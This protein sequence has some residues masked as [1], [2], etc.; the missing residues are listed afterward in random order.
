MIPDIAAKNGFSLDRLLTLC[1]VVDAGS[2][3]LAAGP[4]PTRQ[5]QFSRQIKELEEAFGRKLFIREGKRLKATELGEQLARMA[6]S[7]FGAVDALARQEAGRPETLAIGA[8]EA[9]LRWLLV[10]NFPMLRQLD[11]PIHSH[12]RGLATDEVVREIALGR[13][14]AGVIRIDAVPEGLAFE[15]VGKLRYVLVVPRRLLLTRDAGEIHAGRRIPFVELSGGGQLTSLAAGVA[16]EAGVVLD[17]VLLADTF[18]MLLAAVEHEDVAAFLPTPATA[19]LP[20]S[21]FAFPALNS[22]DRLTREL[23]VV[24]SPEAA[25]QRAVLKRGLAPLVRVLQQALAA[26]SHQ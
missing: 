1:A 4:N 23:A 14:D 9:V 10:P 8:G 20:G 25:E 18:S 16:R 19:G 17:R 12:A 2:I 3:A 24:W 21:R 26:P 13:L 5:S 15:S 22:I 7:F 6:R 11:P